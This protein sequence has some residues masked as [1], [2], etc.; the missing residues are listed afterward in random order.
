MHSN[1]LAIIQLLYSDSSS[2][3]LW[4]IEM[5]NDKFGGMNLV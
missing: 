4:D 3:G 1:A 2:A 5:N